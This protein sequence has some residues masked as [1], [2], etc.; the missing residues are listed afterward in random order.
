MCTY[1][2]DFREVSEY[3]TVLSF[4]VSTFYTNVTLLHFI[5]MYI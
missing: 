1:I 2:H 4:H 5:Y 3:L